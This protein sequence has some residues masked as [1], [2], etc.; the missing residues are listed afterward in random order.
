MSLN[1][2]C[3]ITIQTLVVFMNFGLVSNIQSTILIVREIQIQ[4]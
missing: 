3:S 1:K 2:R 4:H